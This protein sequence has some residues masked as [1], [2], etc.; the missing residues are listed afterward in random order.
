MEHASLSTQIAEIQQE[1]LEQYQEDDNNRPWIVGFSGGKDS[2]M[3]LQL[4]WKTLSDL[5]KELR[6]RKVY[7]VCNNTLVENPKIIKYTERVLDKIEEAAFAQSM[8]VYV[9]RTT[10]ELENSF[11]VNMLG[12]GYPAPTNSFRWCTERLKI[13][14][15]T[16]FIKRK[17]S[18]VGEAII[19]LGTRRDESA[20]RAASINKHQV[21]GERLRRHILPNAYVFTPITDIATPQ[22]WQYL[23][24]VPSPWGADNKQLNALYRDANDGDCPLVIDEDTPSCGKSR[25][26]CWVCTVVQADKSMKALIDNGEDWMEPLLELRNLLYE[27]RSDPDWRMPVRRNG[28]DGIGPYWPDKRALLLEKLLRAQKEIQD[29]GED[30]TLINY[31]ELVAIQVIW[32]RDAI[33]EHNVA[34]IYNK[35]FGTQ[36]LDKDFNDEFVF[37]KKMLREICTDHPED[38]QLITELLDLQKS[39]TILMNN[40]G[41]TNDM[42]RRLEKFLN[43]DVKRADANQ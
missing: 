11:W 43:P 35:V 33:F 27:K 36:F 42:D 29:A 7:V 4:V 19:L 30:F 31:Q 40:Y 28:S 32:Y 13:S 23:N 38:V 12:L 9:E 6:T 1:I 25:F 24:Q 41:L 39:K 15:T 37:E 17:I 21:Q 5:P 16:A 22:L 20:K 34:D 2:T 10:P 26:G 18:E 14:P 3:L 8:P